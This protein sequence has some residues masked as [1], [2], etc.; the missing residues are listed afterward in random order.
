MKVLAIVSSPRRAGNSELAAKEILMRLP[1][2]W[3][4]RMVRL[5]ELNLKYCTA[6]YACVPAEKSCKL[7]DD[8]GFFA[9]QVKWADKIVI[10]APAYFLGMHTAMKLALDRFLAFVNNYEDF[11]GRDCVFVASYGRPKYDGLVKEDML[12]FAKKLYLNVVD[13]AVMLATNPGDSVKGE[14]LQILHR[15]A[16]S[17]QNPPA[18]PLSSGDENVCP[19]CGSRA[20]TLMQSG[21]FRCTVCSGRGFVRQAG[22]KYLLEADPACRDYNFTIEDTRAHA[23]YLADMKKLFLETKEKIKELQAKYAGVDWWVRP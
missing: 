6:C 19:Y 14:N 1:D 8:F 20:I 22:G 16:E 10:A 17:L 23:K 2:D 18:E 21:N 7:D 15:L 13:F 9:E 11:T 5:N 3:E 4:K 12:I